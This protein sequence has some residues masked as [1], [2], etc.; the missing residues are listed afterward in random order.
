MPRKRTVTARR[1]RAVEVEEVTVTDEDTLTGLP[2]LEVAHG[3]DPGPIV[4]RAL[5]RAQRDGQVERAEYHLRKWVLSCPG[6]P[7]PD[8]LIR[9]AV[10]ILRA[11]PD[12]TLMELEDGRSI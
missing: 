4:P 3:W 7:V 6:E 5:Y 10:N 1:T 11:G 9:E 12:A 2:P 8:R